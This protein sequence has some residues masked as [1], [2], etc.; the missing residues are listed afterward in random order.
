MKLIIEKLG[1]ELPDPFGYDRSVAGLDGFLRAGGIRHFSGAEVARP[2]HPEIA[3]SQGWPGGNL[4]PPRACWP[5]GLACLLVAEQVRAHIG[6]PVL[7]AN[8]WRPDPYNAAVATSG[9]NSDHPD[10][11]AID[12]QFFDPAHHA[13]A[14]AFLGELYRDRSLQLALG[15][16]SGGRRIHV[17]VATGAGRRRW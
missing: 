10:A 1:G 15:V 8:W 16:Y 6:A 13:K 12:L 7:C 11:T 2:H 17:G 3:R 9:P 5:H 4:V 14:A